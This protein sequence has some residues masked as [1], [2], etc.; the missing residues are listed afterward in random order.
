MIVAELV[1]PLLATVTNLFKFLTMDYEKEIKD[2]WKMM[3]NQKTMNDSFSVFMK[4][5]NAYT[6]AILKDYSVRLSG[7]TG[8][9]ALLIEGEI[10]N[11][12]ADLL[13]QNDSNNSLNN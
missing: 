3:H 13:R 2:L 6:E 1:A 5:Q 10:E 9:P 4:N 11:K 12:V 7:I 8:V